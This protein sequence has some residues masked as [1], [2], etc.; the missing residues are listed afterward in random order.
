M[1]SFIAFASV[2]LSWPARLQYG[3]E[4]TVES[5]TSS[6]LPIG[7]VIARRADTS[8]RSMTARPHSSATAR[9]ARQV[10]RGRL[11]SRA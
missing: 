11:V 6:D 7:T 9:T 3:S 1:K 2:A 4:K 8:L 5:L 10:R